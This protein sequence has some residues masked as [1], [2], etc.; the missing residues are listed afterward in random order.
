LL[1]SPEMYSGVFRGRRA[2]AGA[3]A[4]VIGVLAALTLVPSASPEQAASKVR[5]LAAG[6]LDAGGDHTCALLAGGTVRCWG[7]GGDGALGY[8]N[9]N[10]V[11]D[12]ETPGSV[13]P[14]DLGGKAVALA[15]GSDHTCALLDDGTVRCWGSGAH[16][17]LGYGNTQTIGDNE[18]PA[19]VG[20]VDLGPGRK[21]VAL[22][23]GLAFTCALLD[24]GTVRCWGYGGDGALGYGSLNDVGDNE[25]PGSVAPVDLGRKR[26][27]VAISAGDAH[28]CAVLDNGKARCWGSNTYGQLGYGNTRTIGDDESPG[29]VAPVSLGPK[30]KALAISTGARFTCALLDDAS[31]R[32]W[33]SGEHGELGA[34]NTETI[35]DDEQPGSVAPVDLGPGR[36]ALAVSA[37]GTHA[38]ALLGRRTVRCWGS[39]ADG[40]LGYGNQNDIGDDE[41]P[42]SVGPISLIR[43]AIAISAG[44]AHTC[45]ALDNGRIRCFGANGHGQ[46]GYGNTKTI[47]DNE[48][49][50]SAKPVEAG[51]LVV[52]RVKPSLSLALKARRD[53]RW[54]YR[55]RAVGK[56]TGFLADPGTCSG[57]VRIRATTPHVYARVRWVNLKL[58]AGKCSYAA[59]LTVSPRGRWKVTA[60]FPGNGSLKARTARIRR[61]RAG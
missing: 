14:V 19:S 21:A 3:A 23:A 56:L 29:S 4:T 45:A 54:P 53:R 44:A 24:D 11:G 58:G 38:C 18:T 35:G 30:R 33:G 59:T 61:F 25:T 10:D 37:G 40:Q 17:A 22:T 47:G 42:G 20:P 57:Q 36:R 31:V 41:T 46:L 8:G 27:A 49:P 9:L 60:A 15:A 55:L 43:P 5:R 32:C 26:K 1:A 48:K 52:A 51:G 7:Y 39:G 34:G 28:A 16:G 13:A 2:W 12:N 50:A 6:F